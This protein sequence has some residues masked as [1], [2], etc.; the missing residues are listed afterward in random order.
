MCDCHSAD[1]DSADG[2]SAEGHNADGTHRDTGDTLHTPNTHTVHPIQNQTQQQSDTMP[3]RTYTSP[4]CDDAIIAVFDPTA[5]LKATTVLRLL[6]L[7][8]SRQRIID[9]QLRRLSRSPHNRLVEVAP[10]AIA[11]HRNPFY[12]LAAPVTRAALPPAP[13]SL[14]ASNG[15]EADITRDNDPPPHPGAPADDG[16]G[17]P[18]PELTADDGKGTDALNESDPSPQTPSPPS[19]HPPSRPLCSVCHS[20]DATVVFMP[21]KHQL[22]CPSC[23]GRAKK[24]QQRVHNRKER[25]RMEL[26]D[27]GAQ[28]AFFQAR[29]LWCQQGVQDEIHPFV[30]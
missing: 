5:Q 18:E 25:T 26:A 13:A 3:P 15:T 1:G 20:A 29:C 12:S 7:R 9:A 27:T 2:D 10:A 30:S 21:C 17:S 16:C 6:K 28:R 14:I 11:V 23:W 8:R 22:S 24:Q 4:V 19:P